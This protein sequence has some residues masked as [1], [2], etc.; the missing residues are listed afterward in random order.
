MRL[1]SAPTSIAI[2]TPTGIARSAARPS[3]S[4]SNALATDEC[5]WVEAEPTNGEPA[6]PRRRERE[7]VG[8]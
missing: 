8:H 1:A 4:V 3:P 2:S 7:Q 5:A 6:M